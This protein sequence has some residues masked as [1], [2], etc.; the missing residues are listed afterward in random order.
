MFPS[1]PCF[2][3]HLPKE[4]FFFFLFSWYTFFTPENEVFGAGIDLLLQTCSD[5]NH[6]QMCKIDSEGKARKVAGCSCAVI[7]VS[8]VL[9]DL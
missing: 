9:L 7:M 4:V 3:Q 1:L 5:L 6:M 8:F 2:L